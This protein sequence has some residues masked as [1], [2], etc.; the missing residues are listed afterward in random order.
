MAFSTAPADGSKRYIYGYPAPDGKPQ[1]NYEEEYHPVDFH[2]I[3]SV[4]NYETEFTTDRSGFQVVKDNAATPDLLAAIAERNDERILKEYYPQVENILLKFV[5]GAKKVLIFDHTVRVS[6]GNVNADG[7]V[8]NETPESRKPA[9]RAHVD[10]T[11][12]AGYDRVR[13]HVEDKELAQKL[14]K[15]RVRIVNVW[16]PLRGPV[17]DVPLGFVDYRTVDPEKDLHESDLFFPERRGEIYA[18]SPSDKH[19]WYYLKD[20]YPDEVSLIKCFDTQEGVAKLTPHGAFDIPNV[21][22]GTL[23]RQSIEV[24]ALVF[25]LDGSE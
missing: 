12:W 17:Q 11:T 25:D 8:L 7:S 9:R 15:G 5:D 21:P 1:T 23:P 19:N 13:R 22:E 2:D 24:R 10:Q 18:I 6:T 14:L 16:R 4:P 20:Q 3:R